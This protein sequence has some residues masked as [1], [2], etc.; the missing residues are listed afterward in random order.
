MDKAYEK[1]YHYFEDHHPWFINRRRCV[2]SLLKNLSRSSRVLD[3]GCAGGEMILELHAAGFDNC[4]G[5]DTSPDAITT[6]N[7][8]GLHGAYQMDGSSPDLPRESFDI[9]IASDVLEHISDDIRALTQWHRLLAPGGTLICFV[10]A[11]PF[12]WSEFDKLNHHFRRYKRNELISR[13]TQA[14]F[15]IARASY[16][17]CLLL[18]PVL[19]NHLCSRSHN[20]LVNVSPALSGIVNAVFKIENTLLRITPFPFGL[21]IFVVAK[22]E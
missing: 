6:C 2:V 8:K 13:C 14:G 5:I 11:F 20:R 1:G 18:L 7:L 12:L 15:R 10:P 16:W 4:I 17:N 3:I 22:K 21:S 9:I 19:L